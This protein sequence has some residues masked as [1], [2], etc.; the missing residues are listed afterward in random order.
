MP[1]THEQDLLVVHNPLNVNFDVT[2]GGQPFMVPANSDKVYP[3][4]IAEHIAKHLTDKVLFNREAAM[5]EQQGVR[6]LKHS[7]L[8]NQQMRG[9]VMA[10]ILPKIYQ[11]YLEQPQQSEQE[12]ISQRIEEA[13]QAY[14]QQQATEQTQTPPAEL[15]TDDLADEEPNPGSEPKGTTPETSLIDPKKKKPTKAQLIEDCEQLGIELNG[16]ESY[17]ELVA[18][19]KAF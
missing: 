15:T 13:S 17:A 1:T 11:Y 2:W 6:N 12:R 8:G 3:R 4:F 19:I 5:A 14:A 18:K 9:E 10:Q 7:I 16:D